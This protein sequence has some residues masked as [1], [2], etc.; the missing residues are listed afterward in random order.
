[1]TDYG[2]VTISGNIGVYPPHDNTGIAVR[3]NGS[4]VSTAAYFERA[5]NDRP[6]FFTTVMLPVG[7]NEI[8][9]LFDNSFGSQQF[10]D[11]SLY[12][13]TNQ[14]GDVGSLRLNDQVITVVENAV[15]GPAGPAGPTGATGAQGPAG[16]TG[17][18][19]PVGA[20]GAQGPAGTIGPQGPAGLAGADG[21]AAPSLAFSPDVRLGRPGVAVLSGTAAS[22]A[23]IGTVELFAGTTDLGAARIGDEGH[24]SFRDVVGAGTQTDLHAVLTDAAGHQASASSFYDL[25]LGI[26]GE[27][28]T[29]LQERYDPVGGALLSQTAFQAN[30]TVL[31]HAD[32]TAQDDGSIAT[33][34]TG[35]PAFIG[36]DRSSFTD[37]AA[38]DGTILNEVGYHDDG[39]RSVDI[40]AAGQ[41]VHA[42]FD[43]VFNTN[44][45]GSTTVVFD[46][47]YAADLITGF[48][49]KG[50]DHDVVSLPQSDFGSLADVLRNTAMVDG[51]ALI[52][53]PASGDTVTLRGVS[54]ADLAQHPH[55]ITLHG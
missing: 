17:A 42:V 11:P 43:D 54:R 26:G 53:D 3:A 33:T 19:G 28:Y 18:Q 32:I 2:A 23:G 39:S 9:V 27:P 46:P 29:A 44:A 4:I 38:P 15:A 35:A 5:Q 47:G 8:D 37:S 25:T 48:K 36:Q 7:Q 20:T 40:L 50:A 22:T 30:G 21:E 34:Y 10:V 12:T 24:W 52:T 16:A 6:S 1:M 49:V 14:N 55:A 45:Q 31:F 13:V 41:T 51:S